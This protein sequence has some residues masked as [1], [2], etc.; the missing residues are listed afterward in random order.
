MP[1]AALPGRIDGGAHAW[2]V[3][4]LAVA[5]RSSAATSGGATHSWQTSAKDAV[6]SDSILRSTQYAAHVENQLKKF[7]TKTSSLLRADGSLDT[8][9]ETSLRRQY[10]KTGLEQGGVSPES[11]RLVANWTMANLPLAN[12]FALCHGTNA[13]FEM[14][15]LKRYLPAGY[16]VWGTELSPLTAKLANFTINWDFHV[17]KPEWRH[18][19]DFVF[20][21]ALDHSPNAR[22]AV[23]RWMEEVAPRGALII[24][25]CRMDGYTSGTDVFG[26]SWQHYADVIREA[27]RAAKERFDVVGTFDNVDTLPKN[28]P[29]GHRTE[30]DRW[31]R[32]FRVWIVVQRNTNHDASTARR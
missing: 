19:A 8:A 31:K 23:T 18:A 1:T 2:C 11:M 6:I 24:E 20:S 16:Q 26:G 29:K 14:E 10:E 7:D 9:K 28:I 25:W 5:A 15:Y 32:Q 22:L 27:G 3:L 4:I 17:V 12:R 13:G 30:W 21:N